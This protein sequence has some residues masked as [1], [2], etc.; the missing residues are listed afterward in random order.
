MVGDEEREEEMRII[1]KAP[2]KPPEERDVKNEPHEL[3]E[4]VGGN[5]ETVKINKAVLAVV[6]EEGIIR[7]LPYNCMLLGW[8]QLPR[9]HGPLFFVGDAWDDFCSLPETF[10]LDDAEEVII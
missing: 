9:I 5:M 8:F 4:L 3:Q 6:N 1:Y 2:G 7:N 10:T